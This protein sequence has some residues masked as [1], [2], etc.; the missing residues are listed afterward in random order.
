MQGV[1]THRGRT[2]GAR[3]YNFHCVL[4][5]FKRGLL[6]NDNKERMQKK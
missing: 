2:Q 3:V 6:E 4:V 5:G 1:V